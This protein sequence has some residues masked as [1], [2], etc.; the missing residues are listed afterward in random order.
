MM[1]ACLRVVA[2]GKAL[3]A[4]IV[5]RLLRAY[6]EADRAEDVESVFTVVATKD[7]VPAAAK[8]ELAVFA[9]NCLRTSATSKGGGRA[10][11]AALTLMAGNGAKDDPLAMLARGLTQ[12]F[13]RTRR[14]EFLGIEEWMPPAWATD[15]ASRSRVAEHP[16]TPVIVRAFVRRGFPTM[17]DAWHP[18]AER[19]VDL[20]YNIV[21]VSSEFDALL[22]RIDQFGT[23]LVDVVAHG[24][25]LSR[26]ADPAEL[27]AQAIVEQRSY[28]KWI[29]ES[30]PYNEDSYA[31]G[32][33]LGDTAYERR[34]PAT[35]VVDALLAVQAKKGNPT[36]AATQTEP[37]VFERFAD[38]VR[39]G[40]ERDPDVI[41]RISSGCP[42]ELR[43]PIVVAILSRHNS[44]ELALEL[45]PDVPS[46]DWPDLLKR[47]F[48][49]GFDAAEGRA[50]CSRAFVVLKAAV[51][52]L[53]PLERVSLAY[54]LRPLA[55]I[56]EVGKCRME[57]C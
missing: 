7:L 42:A 4:R 16:D 33:H 21:D 39:D 3:T 53:P 2:K 29:A 1:E 6:S 52:A 50:Q 38:R 15:A 9:A 27:L 23:F 54:E 32:E 56:M 47:H 45:L 46:H 57:I 19:L 8:R 14:S 20:L 24:A 5:Q 43:A 40:G 48:G 55:K 22:A 11:T 44:F 12:G 35:A 41:R 51:Q 25:A 17:A 37:L 13:A 10:F 18:G 36:W 31:E 49:V 30:Y 34:R 26:N 28:E